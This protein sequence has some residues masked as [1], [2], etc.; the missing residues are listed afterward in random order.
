MPD[1]PDESPTQSS[2]VRDAGRCEVDGEPAVRATIGGEIT[3]ANSPA[4]RDELLRLVKQERPRHVV[5]DLGEVSY[6]DSSAIAVL[7]EVR[8]ALRAE[9]GEHVR[10]ENLRPR[11]RG[12]L[13]I[14]RLES[15]FDMPGGDD[16]G[17]ND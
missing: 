9:G 12:L 15:I 11:V 7:V 8:R 1:E 13:Q 17:G 4:V 10:L 16:E 6:M 5:L 14:S 2:P 3:L